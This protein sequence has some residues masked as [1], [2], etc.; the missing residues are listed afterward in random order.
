MTYFDDW[1][2]GEQT[3][4]LDEMSDADIMEDPFEGDTADDSSFEEDYFEDYPA[5]SLQE[6][7]DS[8]ELGFN[9]YMGTYDYD[10]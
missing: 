7:W 5:Y 8:L 9:P 1:F 10:C 6:D 4:E 3:L 2:E